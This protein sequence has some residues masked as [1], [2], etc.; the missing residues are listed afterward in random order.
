MK[1]LILMALAVGM[2]TACNS[3]NKQTTEENMEQ[4]LQLTQEWDKTFPLSD[5]VEHKKVTFETQ[6]G[7][8]LAADYYTPKNATGKLPA[9]A[10][11]GPFGAVNSA[12]SA[13]CSTAS[14]RSCSTPSIST[15]RRSSPTPSACSWTTACAT[16]TASSSPATR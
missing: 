12:S 3:G 11:S 5:K 1:K 4:E 2:L 16:T 8:T 10:I 13:T 6:Y 7:L 9:I 14:R 15:R